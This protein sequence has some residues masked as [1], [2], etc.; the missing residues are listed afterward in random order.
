MNFLSWGR[1]RQLYKQNGVRQAEML[2]SRLM[3]PFADEIY[4]VE[5]VLHRLTVLLPWVGDMTD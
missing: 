5:K 3:I 1:D 4:S 2:R